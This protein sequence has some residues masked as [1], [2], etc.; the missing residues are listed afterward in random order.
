M[1][2]S[3]ICNPHLL[4]L[5]ARV[6]H[7]NTLVVADSM[8]PHWPGL[9][10][11]DLSLKMGR[12]TLPEVVSAILGQWKA[13]GAWMA[14]EFIQH[15]PETVVREFREALGDTP[16]HWEPHSMLKQRVPKALGVIRTGEHR[17][18]TNLILESA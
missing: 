2:R 4:S 12:P 10:E 16:L 15:N 6:R 5:L 8:F 14:E 13:G 18:Y 17:I 1:I 9:V 3:G 7:T 11:V